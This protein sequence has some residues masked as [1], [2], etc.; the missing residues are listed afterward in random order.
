MGKLIIFTAVTFASL[1]VLTYTSISKIFADGEFDQP[2]PNFFWGP[3]H[4]HGQKEDTKIY[5]FTI[6]VQDKVLEDLEAKL[7]EEHNSNREVAPLEG[8]AFQYGFNTK[9]LKTVREYWLNKY[10]WR[11]R[12]KMLN[13]YAQFKT[14][15]AGID[16]HFQ[17]VKSKNSGKYKTTRPL[18]LVHG[19]PGS[20]VELQKIIPMLTDPQDSDVNFEVGVHMGRSV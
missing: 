7:R 12:E 3:K 18:L 19:W 15:I 17:H 6:Q 11:S 1:A 2:L 5:P 16:I 9:Y 10:D 4:L 14:K 20:F 8:I 13:Q